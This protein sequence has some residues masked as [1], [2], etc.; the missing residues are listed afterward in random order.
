MS[1]CARVPNLQKKRTA[2]NKRADEIFKSLEEIESKGEYTF[3][4][5]F[6]NSGFVVLDIN[7]RQVTANFYTRDADEPT[8]SI[9]LTK[10]PAA[11]QDPEAAK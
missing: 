10:N 3:E 5:L 7:D 11:K 9:V 6:I 1:I 2:K 8:V 4:Q